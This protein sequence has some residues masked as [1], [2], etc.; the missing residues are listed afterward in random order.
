MASFYVVVGIALVVGSIA[1]MISP[2][3]RHRMKRYALMAA[4]V[5]LILAVL[6][7]YGQRDDLGGASATSTV[8]SVLTAVREPTTSG[9][10]DES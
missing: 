7:N 3:A 1:W 5:A 10:R 9:G 2:R 6:Y 4:V 8:E